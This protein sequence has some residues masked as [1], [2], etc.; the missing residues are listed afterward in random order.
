LKEIRDAIPAHCFERSTVTSMRHVIQDVAVVL[1]L[2]YGM[3]YIN[4]V[5]ESLGMS[6]LKY[7]VWS[8][9]WWLTGLFM[10]GVWVLAHECGHGAFSDSKTVND[11]VGT[12][13]HSAL[14]VPYH[15][16]RISHS[17]HHQNTCSVENDEVFVPPSSDEMGESI[18]NTPI[19]NFLF[20]CN[21][22][23]LGWPAYLIGNLSGPNKYRGKANS[24]FNPNSA[25][26]TARQWWNVVQSDWALLCFVG[27]MAYAVHTYGWLNVACYYGVP[28]LWV[29]FYLVWI[30]FLQHTD[31]YIPHYREDE[32]TWLRGA[33]ATVDRSMGPFIDNVLHHIGDTHVCHHVFHYLPFY[34]AQEA[35]V[36]IK[37]V[38]GS[39]YLKDDTP[40]LKAMW[41]AWRDCKFV[42]EQSGI[43]FY[44]KAFK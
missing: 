44:Q 42:D 37:K 30:T 35:T 13:L 10:T 4:P 38:I 3:S 21:M 32:F 7:A 29:N 26:F 40:A 2:M 39:Y 22:L 33:L 16:W 20:I 41:T 11:T 15:A 19:L 17:N 24:H 36:A 34:H 6:W 8:A 1:A 18:I 23:L 28:Y 5:T 12:V 27:G 9:M 14:L 25:L 31:T 43:C